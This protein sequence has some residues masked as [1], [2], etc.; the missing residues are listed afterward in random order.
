MPVVG[1]DVVFRQGIAEVVRLCKAGEG[2]QILGIGPQGVMSDATLVA[3]GIDESGVIETGHAE[4]HC[5]GSASSARAVQCSE[6]AR[7]SGNDNGPS[8]RN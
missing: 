2:A 1:E 3:A 4:L 5:W 6:I 7:P 8:Y